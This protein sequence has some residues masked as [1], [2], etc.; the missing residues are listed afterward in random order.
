MSQMNLR[1]LRSMCE[2]L[3]LIVNVV[4]CHKNSCSLCNFVIWKKLLV[5]L[6]LLFWPCH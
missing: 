4:Q 6:A 5:A 2:C 1:C 3:T